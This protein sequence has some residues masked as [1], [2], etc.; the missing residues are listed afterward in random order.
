MKQKLYMTFDSKTAVFSNLHVQL[1]DAAAVRKFGDLVN[2]GNLQNNEFFRH[3]EDYSLF[4]VGEY[5]DESGELI[6]SLPKSLVTASALK[7][8]NQNGVVKTPSIH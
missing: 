6:G 3:P 2:D 1:S 8:D 7:F 5:D 4:Y